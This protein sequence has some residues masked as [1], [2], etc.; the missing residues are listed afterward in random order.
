MVECR[1]ALVTDH[2]LHAGKDCI[3]YFI[4]RQQIL[5]F[6]ATPKVPLTNNTSLPP[7]M[8]LLLLPMSLTHTF[9]KLVRP[10]KWLD[11]A[12]TSV[13]RASMSAWEVGCHVTFQFEG[14]MEGPV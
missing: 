5:R 9:L 7:V 3:F 1:R 6:T 10:G 14:A 12:L 11:L 8:P 2:P 13:D 4:N